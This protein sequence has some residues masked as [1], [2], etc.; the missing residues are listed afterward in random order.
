MT[1]NNGCQ[2]ELVAGDFSFPTSITFDLQ[3]S[4]YLAESGL[5]FGGEASGG[6]IWKITS[7]RNRTLIKEGLRAPVNGL[8]Y[9]EGHL[10]V[11]E[12]GHPGRISRLDLK[13]NQEVMLDDLPGPGN[14]H[15]NMVVIGPD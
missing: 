5:P 4:L 15:T 1:S 7:D 12:G 6:R 13:G 8:T 2:I 11:S 14:Y 3:G 9:Y 10:Y